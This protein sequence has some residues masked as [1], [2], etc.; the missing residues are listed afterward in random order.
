MKNP[1]MDLKDF[2]AFLETNKTAIAK[3]MKS[4]LTQEEIKQMTME[5][6]SSSKAKGILDFK[7]ILDNVTKEG[8]YNGQMSIVNH[9]IMVFQ[10][11]IQNFEEANV[12]P[13][14]PT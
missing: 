12:T 11:Q 14:S 8:Y 3:D 9:L 7:N 13:A 6:L 5:A 4:L 2:V 1:V 10:K